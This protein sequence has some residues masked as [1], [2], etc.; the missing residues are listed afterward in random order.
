MAFNATFN[1]ISLILWLSFLVVKEVD[2]INRLICTSK[3]QS[4]SLKGV[5]IVVIIIG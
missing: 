4:H 2:G 3:S 5:Y 1:N